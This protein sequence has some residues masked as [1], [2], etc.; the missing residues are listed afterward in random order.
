MREFPCLYEKSKKEYK[1]KNVVENAWKQVAEKL[2]FLRDGKKNFCISIGK[3]LIVL[4]QNQSKDF[5]IFE[6]LNQIISLQNFDRSL[7]SVSL[8][9]L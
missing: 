8:G 5:V 2:E 6:R 3:I 4:K 1:D 9:F 7:H